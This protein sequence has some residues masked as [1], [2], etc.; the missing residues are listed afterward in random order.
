MVASTELDAK[1]TVVALAWHSVYDTLDD[2]PCGGRCMYA[3]S[4]II[5]ILWICIHVVWCGGTI[6][7]PQLAII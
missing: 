3:I 6:C 2:G 4:I 1:T 7:L 5:Y